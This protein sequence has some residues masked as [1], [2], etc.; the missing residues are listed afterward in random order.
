MGHIKEP[1]GI[2]FV[3]DSKPITSEDRKFI[4]ETIAYFK[5]TGKKTLPKKLAKKPTRIKGSLKEFA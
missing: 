4:S 1:I 5:A 2:D 3:V